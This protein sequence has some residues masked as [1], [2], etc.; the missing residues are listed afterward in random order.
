MEADARLGRP[1]RLLL[2]P[3]GGF[4]VIP[5]GVFALVQARDAR[6]YC[7]PLGTTDADGEVWVDAGVVGVRQQDALAQAVQ[8][9]WAA[10]WV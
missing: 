3:S 4:P 6:L 5:P 10:H 1:V 8:D 7:A 9:A 2:A